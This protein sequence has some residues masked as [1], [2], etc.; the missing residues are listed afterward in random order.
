MI[1][2]L[3]WNQKDY[4]KTS[5]YNLKKTVQQIFF[6]FVSC[7]FFI[8]LRFFYQQMHFLFNI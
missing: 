5:D 3:K 8:I 1:K 7:I 6:I 2:L 4:W